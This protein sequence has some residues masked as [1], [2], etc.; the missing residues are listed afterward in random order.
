MN[1]PSLDFDGPAIA[2]ED[3]PSIARDLDRVK[4][5]MVDGRWRGL[6]EI[7]AETGV[8][9]VSVGSRVRDL[10]KRRFG[11]YVVER[12]REGVRRYVYRLGGVA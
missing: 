7:A 12:R 11:G 2:P 6:E 4:R 1:Q 9:L 10:R 8:S 3:V 5:L